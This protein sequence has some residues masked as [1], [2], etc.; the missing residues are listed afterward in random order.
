MPV[1]IPHTPEED[2]AFDE[3]AERL[4]ALLA[5]RLA[6]ALDTRPLKTIPESA[7]HL[8][9]STTKAYDLIRDGMFS[10]VRIG[11]QQRVEPAELDRYI[12]A[13]RGGGDA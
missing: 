6:K 1:E 5:P 9:V 13:C 3:L 2:E 7:E 11:E 12:A 4:A 8:R 10:T